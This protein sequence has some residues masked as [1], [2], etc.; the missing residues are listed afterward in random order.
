[1]QARDSKIIIALDFEDQKSTLN[2]VKKLD[3]AYCRLKIGSILFTRFGPALVSELMQIGFDIFLDLKF[4]DIPN[5]VAGACRVA[6]EL[7]VWMLTVHT[8]GGI[9]MLSM[10][11]EAA[12]FYGGATQPLVVGV[13]VL[14]SLDQA[15]LTSLNIEAP[16]SNLVSDLAESAKRAGLDGVVCSAHEANLLRQQ[17]PSDF[18]LITPGIRLEA[19]PS[20]DQKR[21]MT[22]H[23]AFEAGAD[24]LVMGR[25]IIQSKDPMSILEKLQR[26]YCE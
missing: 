26:P 7:G 4:H 12:S 22:P 9:E 13:T 8:M 3:P 18:L 20:G 5:T 14:T 24:Y 25:S 23:A 2:F 17:L 21:I 6:A 10:A 16:L 11:K 19:D 15:D 1:M